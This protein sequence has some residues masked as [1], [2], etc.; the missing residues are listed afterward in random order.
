MQENIPIY[1]DELAN[2]QISESNYVS[3][4]LSWLQFNARVLDQVKNTI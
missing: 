4:D 2:R 1:A 3:R